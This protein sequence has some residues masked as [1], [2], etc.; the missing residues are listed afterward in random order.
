MTTYIADV[1]ELEADDRWRQW[2]ARGAAQDRRTAARMRKV[3]LL[4]LAML[5]IWSVVQLTS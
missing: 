3:T 1:A 4:V 2:Q 5:M